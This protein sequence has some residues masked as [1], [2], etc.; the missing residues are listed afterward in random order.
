MKRACVG[1]FSIIDT[2]LYFKIVFFFRKWYGGA[3]TGLNWLRI[4]TGGAYL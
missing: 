1:V 4:G 2:F 3:W